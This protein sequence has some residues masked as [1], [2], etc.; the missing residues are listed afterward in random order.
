M[1]LH[2]RRLVLDVERLL[3]EKQGDRAREREQ[4]QNEVH[5]LWALGVGQR[6]RF[7][8]RLH[9]FGA[10]FGEKQATHRTTQQL[11]QGV[12]VASHAHV[13]AFL[14]LGGDGADVGLELRAPH[15]LAHG[16]D[17]DLDAHHGEV[18]AADVR[19]TE[20]RTEELRRDR[21]NQA[22]RTTDEHADDQHPI[23]AEAF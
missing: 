12:G 19:S 3:H 6:A 11:G 22:G 15:K 10:V 16:E 5:E 7:D 13:G 8:E 18:D 21:E 23:D 2:V 20:D 9:A 4:G 14:A 1:S 17:H